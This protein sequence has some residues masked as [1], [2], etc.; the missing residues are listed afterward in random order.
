MTTY[1]LMDGVSG[2]PGVGSSGTQPPASV[3]SASGAWLLGTQFSVLGQMAWLN[4]YY[5]WVAANGDTGPQKFALWNRYSSST[6]QVVP[7]STV[8][9]GALT[10]GAM[11]LVALSSPIQLGPGAQYIAATGWTATNGIPLNSNQFD[12]GDPYAS[13]IVNGILTGWSA[14][15]GS[16]GYPTPG[17]VGGQGLFSNVLGSDPGAAMPNNGSNSDNFWV[18]VQVSNTAPPAYA[19]SYRLWPNKADIGN[20]SLDTANNFTLGT[21]FS[22]SQ[23]CTIN[24]VW[25]YSPA[26]VS[27]LPTAIG[28]Y[29][30]SNTTLVATQASPS[31]SGAAASGW[32]SAPLTGTLQAGVNYKVVVC[33]GAG[34]PSIWNAAVANYWST[35]FGANGLTSGPITAPNNATATSPGQ[36]SYNLGATIAYPGTNAGPYDYGV[37][38]ELTP[39]P[40]A[41][42]TQTVYSMRMM[43]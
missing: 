23:A 20:Y 43:P 7:G 32:I 33:N 34:S 19:G 12:S 13:G 18:D 25:F 8:T 24:N 27:Q 2:R 37:D 16:N 35:G 30:V 41:T 38:I 14:A 29:Q 21:E 4:G 5:V 15:T 11:N 6:Q 26:T 39:V 42:T 17:Y 28:V 1:R 31:W 40:A 36:E 10:A 22:L 3:T 9:S